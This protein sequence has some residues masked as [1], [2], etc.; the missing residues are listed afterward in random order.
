MLSRV[1]QGFILGPTLFVVYINDNEN[2]TNHIKFSND[3]KIYGESDRHFK[4]IYMNSANGQMTGK[5]FFII[6]CKTLHV[7][8]NSRHNYHI[9]SIT[10][11]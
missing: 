5:C 2:F 10:L 3:T 8:H 11:Q 7:G 9:D 6:K 1:P 4:E